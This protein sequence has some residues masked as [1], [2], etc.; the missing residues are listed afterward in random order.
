MAL[1]DII[2]VACAVAGVEVKSSNLMSP[3]R[4]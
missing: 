2:A 1:K 4:E 3:T